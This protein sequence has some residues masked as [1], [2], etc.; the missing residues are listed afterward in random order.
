M[1]RETELSW[2][3]VT[4]ADPVEMA[5]FR[6]QQERLAN[7]RAKAAFERLKSLGIIDEHGES[8]GEELPP[9]M[10]SGAKRDFGASRI[11][12]FMRP[13]TIVVAGPP[14]SGKSV[15]FPV[16]SLIYQSK[17]IGRR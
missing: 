9:D 8:V 14:G 6:V 17:A 7:E 2:A 11:R 15:L 3:T 13:R 16:H 4:T 5:E 1:I 12:C 10:H